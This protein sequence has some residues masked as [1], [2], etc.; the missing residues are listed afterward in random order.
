MVRGTDTF[1]NIGVSLPMSRVLMA[2]AVILSAGVFIP[3]LPLRAVVTLPL[4]LFLPGQA[5]LL[6]AFGPGRRLDWVPALSLGVLLSMAFYPLAGLLL[7]AASVS[8]SAL[9][10]IASV[11]VLI[12][13]AASM[14]QFRSRRQRGGGESVKW[15]PAP[16]P[17]QTGSGRSDLRIGALVIGTVVVGGLALGLALHF[18]PKAFT[19]PYTEFYFAQSSRRGAQPVSQA[20]G[21]PLWV[22]V[23]VRNETGRRQVY[24][25]E[26]R[27]D[28]TSDWKMRLV[29]LSPGA[30]WT[31]ALRGE[32]PTRPGLHQLSIV[33]SSK[34]ESER[35][36]TLTCWLQSVQ[37]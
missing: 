22:D 33:L 3:N 36:G 27:V 16:P 7:Y 4:A 5:I 32:M 34:T 6:I 8:P 31:G 24:E 10:V 29:A 19:T 13:V 37:P 25:I 17:V 26:P 23:T 14:N 35:I 12:V 1:T 21:T 20:A 18:A 2:G 9:S 15:M 30:K 11:D 28:A